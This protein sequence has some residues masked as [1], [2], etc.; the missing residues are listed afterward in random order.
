MPA[1]RMHHYGSACPEIRFGVSAERESAW[2]GVTKRRIRGDTAIWDNE[3]RHF[4][5][6]S[7]RR[8]G[9]SDRHYGNSCIRKCPSIDTSRTLEEEQL[10]GCL[11]AGQFFPSRFRNPDPRSVRDL[12]QIQF[13]SSGQQFSTGLVLRHG[14]RPHH[15][16]AG[17]GRIRFPPISHSPVTCCCK[18]AGTASQSKK[19]AGRIHQGITRRAA[20]LQFGH[21]TCRTMEHPIR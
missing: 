11:L 3:A 1:A 7:T 17:R 4:R 16:S 19:N 9:F 20:V 12:Q 10:S 14:G 6:R 13:S 5:S 18:V 8:M 15:L 2:R 21:H